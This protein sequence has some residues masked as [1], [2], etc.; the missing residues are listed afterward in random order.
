MAYDGAEFDIG[1]ATAWANDGTLATISGPWFSFEAAKSAP[2]F[3]YAVVR[4]LGDTRSGTSNDSETWEVRREIS[5]W[6]SDKALAETA[7]KLVVDFL[8]VGVFSLAN[9]HAIISTRQVS[10][11]IDEEDESVFRV[12]L[13]WE[14]VVEAAR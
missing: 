13:S 3:P 4:S 9:S 11:R 8:Q 10:R 14:W 1:L 2:A 6:H 5:V 12:S 7:A